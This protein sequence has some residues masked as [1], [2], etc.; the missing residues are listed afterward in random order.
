MPSYN[1][2]G[3]YSEETL[4]NTPAA[5]TSD[6][7]QT[8]VVFI[9]VTDRGPTTKVGNN[10]I[11][12]PTLVSGWNDFVNK[13]SYGSSNDIFSAVSATTSADMRYALHTFFQNNGSRAYVTRVV[14]TDAAAGSFAL[15]AQG[16]TATSVTTTVTASTVTG[17]IQINLSTGVNGLTAGSFVTLSGLNASAAAANKTWVIGTATSSSQFTVTA[18]G[19]SSIASTATANATA[20]FIFATAASPG[21][22]VSA[23]DVGSWSNNLFVTATSSN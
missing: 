21:I 3:V 11:G 6:S 7:G 9:G 12:V 4:M 17:G 15:L 5:V 18:T 1:K 22:V 13:F 20:A 10:I 19:V 14:N 8:S 23:K 2:P 16:A